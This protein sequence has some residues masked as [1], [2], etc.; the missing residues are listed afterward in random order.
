[1]YLDKKLD[2]FGR[3]MQQPSVAALAVLIALISACTGTMG[4][5]TAAR[6]EGGENGADMGAGT[7]GNPSEAASVGELPDG[8]PDAAAVADGD[9]NRDTTEDQ[10]GD[11]AGADDAANPQ[12]GPEGTAE[13]SPETGEDSETADEATPAAPQDGSTTGED[14]T[15]AQASP[16]AR[17]TGCGE[18]AA[19]TNQFERDTISSD[20]QEREYYLRIPKNY[21]P[22]RAYPLVFRFHGSGGNGISGGLDIE[23]SS[24]DDALIVSPS[25]LNERWSFRAE[26]PDVVLF[27]T[28]L[29]ELSATLCIDQRRVFT[30]G[31]SAG[32]TFA[33]LLACTRS[34]WVR[35]VVA[36][37]GGTRADNCGGPV[38]A[39]IIHGKNDE[40]VVPAEGEAARDQYLALSGCGTEN[41]PQEPEPCV[42]YAGCDDSA[43]VM[44]CAT[45]SGHNPQGAF[46]GP[47]AWNFF[48]DL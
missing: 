47:A 22:Q 12:A 15:T 38:A 41:A 32:A 25:G 48:S 10:D 24:R 19:G 2:R 11:G 29:R 37:S 6:D 45:N 44:Y 4:G 26:G 43:P 20:G 36:V 16:A 7:A 1:M 30:Y 13:A 35:G 42:A 27:D 9:V 28:L 31:F 23:A 46:S 5:S 17:S 21:D 34:E 40:V 3:S 8:D 18:A 33:N 14:A 39:M